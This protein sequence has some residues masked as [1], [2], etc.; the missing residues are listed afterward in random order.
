MPSDQAIR[1]AAVGVAVFDAGWPVP[2]LHLVDPQADSMHALT[3]A[4]ADLD[5]IPP[6]ERPVE[7]AVGLR[8]LLVHVLA[9]ALVNGAGATD[10]VGDVREHALY[11]AS[12]VP[13]TSPDETLT[14]ATGAVREWLQWPEV[15]HVVRTVAEDLERERALPGRALTQRIRRL[16]VSQS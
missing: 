7:A 2:D 11:I 4:L 12:H 13:G 14:A 1:R 16:L 8:L 15:Q 9:P 6:G 10:P 5:A 3:T